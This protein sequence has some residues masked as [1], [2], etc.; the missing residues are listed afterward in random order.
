MRTEH[1]NERNEDSNCYAKNV[2]NIHVHE[3]YAIS[4]FLSVKF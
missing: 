2:T 3:F 1:R 4:K